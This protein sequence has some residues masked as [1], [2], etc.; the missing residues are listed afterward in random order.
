[1][2]RI[3]SLVLFLGLS[4]PSAF[5][6]YFT[7]TFSAS[8]INGN[9]WQVSNPFLDSLVFLTGNAATI[10]NHARLLTVSSYSGGVDITVK[11]RFSGSRYDSFQILTRTDGVGT[12][13]T[14]QGFSGLAF[15]FRMQ[16]D[17]GSTANNIAI[18][19]T[20]TPN[21]SPIISQGTFSISYNQDYTV[22]I[23]D[24]G[25]NVALYINNLTTP[26]LT[27][28]DTFSAGSKIALYNREGV[29]NFSLISAGSQVALSYFGVAPY[30][31]LSSPNSKLIAISTRAT[32]GTG[33]GTLIVGFA[34]GG[35]G[36][37]NVIIRA[38]GPAL[39]AF[40]VSTALPKVSL[41]LYQGNTVL[42]SNSGW[43]NATN[44][45]LI[46]STAQNLALFSYTSGS[47]DS[48]I[49]TT[50]QPGTYSAN[51]TS[52]TGQP[53]IALVEIYEVP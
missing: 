4:L 19:E 27:A 23:T 26:F 17:T 52:G 40:G 42:A 35:T 11:F 31:T 45:Q 48:A 9:N 50:L 29:G 10:N 47:G 22:R 13:A 28:K 39:L 18:Q 36:P 14:N 49:L 32:A 6:Q 16:N 3:I 46:S 44:T 5:A 41:S 15:T 25:T 37:K 24:D 1:M 33:D 21:A 43:S 51:A 2:S 30:L 20:T 38:A 12:T 7:D 8:T 34:V 53:G